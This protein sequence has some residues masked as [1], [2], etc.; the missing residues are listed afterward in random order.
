MKLK[1]ILKFLLISGLFLFSASGC[2]EEC[3]DECKLRQ[4]LLYW[5]IYG[6]DGYAFSYFQ[7]CLNADFTM[8]PGEEKVLTAP[9]RYHD[10]DTKFTGEKR[11]AACSD[12]NWKITVTPLSENGKVY[13]SSVYRPG[14]L[15]GCSSEVLA[16][17]S[18]RGEAISI[19]GET[20]CIPAGWEN[21]VAITYTSTTPEDQFLLTF[22]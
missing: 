6:T 14:L 9:K 13:I 20:G 21:G 15:E 22:E 17:S 1:K 18:A 7:P 2:E 19:E 12:K 11:V 16:S 4:S 3:N 5:I 10:Y 8:S